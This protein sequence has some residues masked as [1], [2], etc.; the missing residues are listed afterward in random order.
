MPTIPTHAAVALSL[1]TLFPRASVPRRFWVV[2]AVC[3][4]FPDFDVL[5]FRLGIRYGDFLGHRGFTHSLMFAALLA[6]A[7]LRC[8][9]EGGRRSVVATYLFL[10]AASHGVLD[11]FT[12]G[13]LGVALLAPFDNRRV[14]FPVRPIEVSPIGVAGF[15]DRGGGAVLANELLWV[16]LPSVLIAGSGVW[17]VQRARTAPARGS[18]A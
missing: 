18:E 4:I 6:F 13:G 16:W 2:G 17:F 8:A 14:F 9:I 15:F 5:G 7:G 10:A 12:N 1:G 3:A 11:A